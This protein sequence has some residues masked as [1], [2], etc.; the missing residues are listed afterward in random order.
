MENSSFRMC[1]VGFMVQYPRA[2]IFFLGVTVPNNINVNHYTY[3]K[4]NIIHNNTCFRG[5]F[6]GSKIK[7][8]KLE[9]KLH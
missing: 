7:K 8:K 4:E 6:L 9:L 5:I 3:L 1:K 2:S